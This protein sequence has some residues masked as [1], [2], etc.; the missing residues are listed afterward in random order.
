M[1]GAGS[2]GST[3]L[4]CREAPGE[5]VQITRCYQYLPA[6]ARPTYRDGLQCGICKFGPAPATE[7][8][9]GCYWARG[10]D[11]WYCVESCNSCSPQ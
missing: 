10:S 4:A 11:V 7:V 8:R 1:G 5:Q 9:A 2:G 6:P 3:L